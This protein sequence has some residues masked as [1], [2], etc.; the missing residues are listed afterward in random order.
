M[1]TLIWVVYLLDCSD[2]T[3]Y[4]G[5]TNDLE[6]RLKKHN[7]GKGA[8]YTRGRLPVQLINY[9]ICSSKS[10]ALKKET[11]L[12]KLKKKEKNFMR[13]SD[14]ELKIVFDPKFSATSGV[15]SSFQWNNPDFL[16]GLSQA[17]AL[18]ENEVVLGLIVSV[19][20]IKVNIGRKT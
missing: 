5:I 7:S 4:C 8:K 10:D 17:I 16:K 11:Q 19:D 20:G 3:I 12:K 9:I 18:K 13:N 6:K 14:K 15:F 1:Q 2:G